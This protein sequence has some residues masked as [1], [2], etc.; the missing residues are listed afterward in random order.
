MTQLLLLY[1]MTISSG[2]DL[3]EDLKGT[4]GIY[5]NNNPVFISNCSEIRKIKH[6]ILPSIRLIFF[7][8]GFNYQNI[9]N[10]ATIML[11]L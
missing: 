4:E 1:F 10:K 9:P 11:R 8:M 3:R 7:N 6:L 2:K 5:L